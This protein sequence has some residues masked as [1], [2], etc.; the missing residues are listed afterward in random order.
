RSAAVRRQ[1][2][3]PSAAASSAPAEPTVSPADVSVHVEN[4]SGATGRAGDIAAALTGKGF[5][6]GT[7]ASNAPQQTATTVLRYPAGDKAKAQTVASALGIPAAH[8]SED[9]AVSRVTLVIGTDWTSG[10]SYPGG[11]AKPAPVSTHQALSDSH[12]ETA[13]QSNTCAPVSTFN[14]VELNGVPMTPSQAYARATNV[15]DSAP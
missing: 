12:A 15:P 7:S 5:G 6:S 1:P 13:D 10:T 11:S 9:A 3:S 4:G 14:T 2:S 8:V